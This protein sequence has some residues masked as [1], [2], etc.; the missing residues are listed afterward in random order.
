MKME[1]SKGQRSEKV[2][3]FKMKRDLGATEAIVPFHK[4]HLLRQNQKPYKAKYFYSDR[5]SV[6][7]YTSGFVLLC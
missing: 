1:T 7:E 6:K 2:D 5:V 3:M 4:A